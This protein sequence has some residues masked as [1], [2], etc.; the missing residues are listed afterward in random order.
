M[1]TEVGKN[2]EGKE[3]VQKY[4]LLFLKGKLKSVFTIQANQ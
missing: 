3:V 1:I 4:I 2:S